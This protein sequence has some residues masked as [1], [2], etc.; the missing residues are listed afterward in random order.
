M[1][2]TTSD[3]LY[4][5]SRTRTTHECGLVGCRAICIPCTKKAPTSVLCKPEHG[6]AFLGGTAVLFPSG[7]P[8]LDEIQTPIPA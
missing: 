4:E 7:A 2:H 6:V 5:S 3:V 1:L 8:T